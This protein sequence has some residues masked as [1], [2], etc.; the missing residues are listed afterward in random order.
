MTGFG[1]WGALARVWAWENFDG[2]NEKEERGMH[3]SVFLYQGRGARSSPCRRGPPD[4]RW[5]WRGASTHNI[6]HR[7]MQIPRAVA[8]VALLVCALGSCSFATASALPA[9]LH[10]RQPPPPPPPPG[11]DLW[12]RPP[13]GDLWAL[14]VAGSAGW[15][16][17]R[18]QADVLHAYAVLV[19]RG[20][21][22][23][24]IIL[25]L[26]DDLPSHR[27]NPVPGAVFNAPG[28]RDLREGVTVDY[29]GADVN[30][31]NFL[32]VLVG[33]ANATS[34]LPSTGRVLDALTPAD[35]L[36]VFYSDHGGPGLL[37][38]PHGPPVYADQFVG[39]LGRV[40]AGEVVVV[41]EA[42]DAGSSFQGLVAGDDE[43]G[44]TTASPRLRV[45][46]AS[47]PGEPSWAT[48]CPSEGAEEE[49]KEGGTGHHAP[50][51]FNT[52]LGDAFAVAW[53]TDA[54]GLGGGE[55]SAASH[56][57][58][59]LHAQF[60]RLKA[61]VAPRAG[62]GKGGGG[63]GGGGGGSHVSQYGRTRSLARSTLASDVEGARPASVPVPVHDGGPQV[64]QWGASRT[65]SGS[66]R[67]LA[68]AESLASL[69][70]LASAPPRPP[71]AP[72]V[73]DWACFRRL[74]D[75]W[76]VAGCGGGLSGT[77]GGANTS[78]PLTTD[79]S[80]LR[81]AGVLARACNARV[82]EV[83]VARLLGRVCGAGGGV[84]VA[85]S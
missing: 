51:G 78:T 77:R 44:N 61:A 38:M 40:A 74:G 85:T 81:H 13:D 79:Q 19:A 66:F 48:F 64:A 2:R 71:T 30:A 69:E 4:R 46:T 56:Q 53:L 35:R 18:H 76:A 20:V 59:T 33:D 72:L 36:L 25:M 55:K 62:R 26:A 31:D 16:N 14:L 70:S 32:A 42:C 82:D 28:G 45:M 5:R 80:S 41:V 34:P 24:R 57:G 6:M 27:L 8:V 10:P 54:E 65:R 52:C 17:Y 49:G 43:A 9:I 83:D 12:A 50:P 23:D 47:A 58:Q 60:E 3:S 84:M 1:G 21:P 73:D 29:S 67:A 63:S 39:A 68:A 22:G 15:P 11:G 7:G 37:G 75:A